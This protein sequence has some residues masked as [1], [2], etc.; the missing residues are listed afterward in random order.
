M[1]LPASEVNGII[2]GYFNAHHTVWDT[3]VNARGNGI[4]KCA[5]K[6]GTK[7]AASRK[8]FFPS[9]FGCSTPGK[10]LTKGIQSPEVKILDSAIQHGSNHP[11]PDND[12]KQQ[13]RGAKIE[14]QYQNQKDEILTE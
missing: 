9:T 12:R 1:G 7:K 13:Q 8:H 10:T 11:L 3:N 2:L 6:R 5:Q 14:M 4:V